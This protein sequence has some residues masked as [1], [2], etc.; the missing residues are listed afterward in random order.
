MAKF[1]LEFSWN[2]AIV[3]EATATAAMTFE[4]VR[5]FA[6]GNFVKPQFYPSLTA[7]LRIDPGEVFEDTHCDESR[8]QPGTGTA[9]Y[10][11]T[12]IA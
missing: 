8:G 1:A 12:R 11:I 10:R 9:A 3:M 7:I 6:L 5:A 4:T 2:G